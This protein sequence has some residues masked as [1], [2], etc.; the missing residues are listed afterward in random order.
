L[1]RDSSSSP[2]CSSRSHS[3]SSVCSPLLSSTGWSRSLPSLS[4][5]ALADGIG[6]T[7]TAD[8]EINE[9]GLRGPTGTENGPCETLRITL[10]GDSFAEA[11]QVPFERTLGS[12]PER[13]LAS[14]CAPNAEVIGFG[15]SDDGAA[16][17]LLTLRK[18]VWQCEP[19]IGVQAYLRPTTLATTSDYARDCRAPRQA[20]RRHTQ[21]WSP[22]SCRSVSGTRARQRARRPRVLRGL[23]SQPQL[24]PPDAHDMKHGEPRPSHEPSPPSSR[25]L[26][27]AFDRFPRTAGRRPLP[28]PRSSVR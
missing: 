12:V 15:V 17:E 6:A 16:H 21:Q 20:S 1:G 10:L 27:S 18:H 9:H 26:Q 28:I 4:D 24:R 14:S 8:V 13:V 23:E 2:F 3:E 19:E 7:A 25:R 5:P 22:G 11:F